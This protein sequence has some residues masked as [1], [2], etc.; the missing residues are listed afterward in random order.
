RR[1]SLQRGCLFT[2]GPVRAR[3]VGRRPTR[4]VFQGRRIYAKMGTELGHS[5]LPVGCHAS[6]QPRLVALAGAW[7]AKNFSRIPDRSCARVLPDLCFSLAA[8]TKPRIPAAL[9]GGN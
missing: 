9:V 2:V 1:Q 5:A 6:A 7:R 4:T 3:L 8:D